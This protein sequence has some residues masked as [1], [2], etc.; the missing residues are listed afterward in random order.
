MI[1]RQYELACL[2][3]FSYLIG[4]KT[5]GRAVVVDPQ[6]DISQYVADARSAGLT[7][8]RVIETHF[9]ADFLSGHL[10]LAA[11]TGAAVTYGEQ[12]RGKAEFPVEWAADGQRFSLGE[13]VLEV[14][15]TP[16]HTPESIC[17]VV[18]EHAG[19]SPFGV[20]TG[21]TLFI[22]DVGRPDLLGFGHAPEDMARDLFASLHTK[23]LPLPD[24]TR[25]YPA[26]GAGSACGR[27]LSV[28]PLSTIGEQRL[29][30]YALQ[31]MSETDFVAAVLDSQPSVPQYF[32]YDAVLNRQDH[33]LF[34]ENARPPAMD[35]G[36]AVAA[37]TGGAVLLDTR[38][39]TD[40]AA[41]HLRGAI[42]VSLD[43]RF[44]EY[45][46]AV[47]TPGT[48]IVLV[49]EEGREAEATTRLARIGFDT[50]VGHVPQALMAMAE[51]PD[52]VVRSS[53]LTAAQ[54]HNRLEYLEDLQVV[55]VR[56]R[57]EAATGMIAGA[58]LV[59]LPELPV[60]LGELS[61]ERPVV[62]VCTAGG[63]SSTAASL[64]AA[65]GFADVSDLIGGMAGWAPG[66]LPD[67][68]PSRP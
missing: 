27:S 24:A 49:G 17:V 23:L 55:D 25:V 38:S 13:V 33:P 39:A 28:L 57:G 62:V 43:S 31:P 30:N 14:L 2:S 1:F 65:K 44:A 45:S 60:R 58:R 36:E 7:I 61:P 51:H 63:R 22:G 19:D 34:D 18:Y 59:P 16:G 48:P 11:A 29:V 12:G 67:V 20:L 56:D 52:L 21:D 32:P 26:H 6:R 42:N 46:G 47:V 64:L 68:V 10:E 37:Q 66:V 15:A 9:H 54:L 35:P 41:G 4:D 50:V 8:E 5:T 3:L 53:R 40:F